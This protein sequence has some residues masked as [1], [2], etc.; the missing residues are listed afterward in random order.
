M[1]VYL[2]TLQVKERKITLFRLSKFNFFLLVPSLKASSV[3]CSGYS[4]VVQLL[5]L[6]FLQVI[7]LI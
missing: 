3:L 2:E 5:V 6:P 7:F 4:L 1:Y